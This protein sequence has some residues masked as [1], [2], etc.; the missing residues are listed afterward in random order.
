MKIMIESKKHAICYCRV[1]TKRQ[2][3]DGMSLQAQRDMIERYCALQEFADYTLLIDAGVSGT[4]PLYQR[5]EGKRIP[6]LLKQT[7]AGH[8][9]TPKLDRAFR[10][11]ADACAMAEE[12]NR[13]GVALHLVDFGGGPTNT[14]TAIGKMFLTVLAGFAEFERNLI[15]ERT[16]GAMAALTADGIICSNHVPF[17][18]V[19]DPENPKRMVRDEGEQE[20]IKTIVKLKKKDLSYRAIAK[21]L[22]QMGITCRGGPFYHPMIKRILGRAGHV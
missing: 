7:G 5:P 10:S 19:R 13:A 6:K 21:E 18:Y 1:S 11:A 16:K 9:I 8:I 22:E 3:T 20:V 17:G 15:S 2:A 4:V 14:S 12:W